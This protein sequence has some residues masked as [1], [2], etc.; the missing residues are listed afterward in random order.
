VLETATSVRAHHD[1]IGI[2]ALGRLQQL[3][4]RRAATRLT[5]RAN[6]RDLRTFD[7]LVDETPRVGL[8]I[9]KDQIRAG[10]G[11]GRSRHDERIDDRANTDFRVRALRKLQRDRQR[12]VRGIGAVQSDEDVVEHRASVPLR[13]ETLGKFENRFLLNC[14]TPP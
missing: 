14:F 8:Q 10:A 6:A 9:A 13:P 4:S 7:R 5:V 3:E 12:F 2:A 1:E 11:R